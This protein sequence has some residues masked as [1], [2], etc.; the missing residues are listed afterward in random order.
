MSKKIQ[1]SITPN[2]KAELFCTYFAGHHNMELFNNAMKSYMTAYGYLDKIQALEDEISELENVKAPGYTVEIIDIRG[3]IKKIKNIC[4]VEGHHL[5]T[6]PNILKRVNS[7]MDKLF[8]DKVMDRELAFTATQRKDLNAKIQAIRE[9][10]RVKARVSDKLEGE[11]KFTWEGED[12]DKKI[13]NG[14]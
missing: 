12:K 3:Q 9:Y 2:I 4:A 13:K 5:L 1:K 6:K 14:K 11:F 7:L 10:N 8:D